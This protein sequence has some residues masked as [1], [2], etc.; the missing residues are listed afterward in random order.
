[1]N[2]QAE[3][4]QSNTYCNCGTMPACSAVWGVAGVNGG[5]G[6]GVG[7]YDATLPGNEDVVRPGETAGMRPM[8]V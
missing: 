6:L 8:G 7:G 2:L 5:M 1:M 4:A 3:M